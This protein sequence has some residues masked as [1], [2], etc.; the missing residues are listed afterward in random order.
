VV[1]GIHAMVRTSSAPIRSLR[2][3]IPGWRLRGF[4]IMSM[5]VDSSNV[6]TP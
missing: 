2:I 1:T 4:A 5:G 6:L 3:T